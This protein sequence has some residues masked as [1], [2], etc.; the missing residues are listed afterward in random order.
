MENRISASLSGEQLKTVLGLIEQLQAALP[1]LL[2]LTADERRALPRAGDAG[3]PFIDKSLKLAQ[4]SAG[5]LPR[6]FEVSEFAGDVQLRNALETVQTRLAPLLE[7]LDDTLAAVSADSYSAALEV[8]HYARQSGE[9]AGL[10]E[11]IELM[12]K[13]FRRNRNPSKTDPQ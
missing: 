12:G 4:T 9:G 11:L 1:F 13:R 3:R 2:S 10:D 6:S 7:K 5:F 8:Y